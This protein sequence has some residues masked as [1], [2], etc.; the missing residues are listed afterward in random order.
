MAWKGCKWGAQ[1]GGFPGGAQAEQLVCSTKPARGLLMR[2]LMS[3][4]QMAAVAGGVH[5]KGNVV[6]E[7][8]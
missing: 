5:G 8:K 2:Q 1:G 7:E 6:K 4:H 3:G